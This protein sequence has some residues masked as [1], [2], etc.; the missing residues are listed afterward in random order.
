M[1]GAGGTSGGIGQFFIG[2]AMMCGGFYMLLNAIKVTS[3]FGLGSHLY[4]FGGFGLTSGMVMIP[5]IFGVGMMFYNAKNPFGWLL[6]FGAL[7]ALIFGV[8]SSINF[9]FTYMSAFDLIVIL[10]LSIGGLGLFLRS[11]KAIDNRYPDA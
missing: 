1:K 8:I 5:F 4:Q 9:R 6:T 2:L 7:I 3:S 10:V 11:L